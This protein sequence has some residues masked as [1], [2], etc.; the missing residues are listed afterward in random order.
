MSSHP[1][2][3]SVLPDART[4]GAY[5][6]SV[7]LAARKQGD[8]GL[9]VRVR[10]GAHPGLARK[11]L[12]VMFVFLLNGATIAASEPDVVELMLGV[13]AGSV[14]EQALAEWLR[15]NTFRR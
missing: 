1:L 2:R 6:Y 3:G 10:S 14:D 13:A 8:D 11:H 5:R 15:R 4:S 12:Q 9:S 7:L